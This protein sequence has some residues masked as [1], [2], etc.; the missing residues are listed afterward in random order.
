MKYARRQLNAAL[1][2]KKYLQTAEEIDFAF[3]VQRRH[4]VNEPG[5]HVCIIFDKLL[6]YQ[7]FDQ[8]FGHAIESGY[9]E[10][11]L[12]YVPTTSKNLC[13]KLV[14]AASRVQKRLVVAS[15]TVD[16]SAFA[17]AGRFAS[18]YFLGHHYSRD[19]TRTERGVYIV[20]CYIYQTAVCWNGSNMPCL[21]YSHD[22]TYNTYLQKALPGTRLFNRI[23]ASL[24]IV[25]STLLTKNLNVTDMN[26]YYLTLE[27]HK[28][29]TD[30]KRQ[31][32]Q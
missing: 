20:V 23:H 28:T 22:F 6:Q 10:P 4:V 26:V 17:V 15:V 2:E 29:D 5:M 7:C 18:T 27:K 14:A 9:V 8:F 21:Q 11:Y 31:Q 19:S 1:K 32:P 13:V 12:V 25:S 30:S 24:P 3:K 16:T